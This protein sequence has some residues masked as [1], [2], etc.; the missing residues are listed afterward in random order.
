MCWFQ[1]HDDH[2]SA[3][4]ETGGVLSLCE[5]QQLPDW[6]EFPTMRMCFLDRLAW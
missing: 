1:Q 5:I 4:C 3:K 2:L 6:T